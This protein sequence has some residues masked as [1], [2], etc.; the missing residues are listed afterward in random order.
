LFAAGRDARSLHGARILPIG[1]AT[2]DFVRSRGIIPDFVPDTF[3]SEGIIEVL[4]K[5][6]VRGRR[7]LLPRAEQARDIIGQY[8][9]DQGGACDVIPVY[10]TTLPDNTALPKEKPDMVTFTSAS[11]AENFITL[12]GSE[13]LETTTVASIGP[14]TTEALKSH[15][16]RVDITASRH[17]VEGLVNAIVQAARNPAAEQ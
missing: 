3:T 5:M 8:I 1:A 12:F 9:T 10:R 15:H 11:T 17:D 16:V 2:A 14:I 4:Q 6:E 7:F 13:I